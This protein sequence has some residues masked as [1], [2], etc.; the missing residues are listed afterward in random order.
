M[1]VPGGGTLPASKPFFPS[2]YGESPRI[3]PL[4]VAVKT[5]ALG[6]LPRHFHQGTFRGT[7]TVSYN[8]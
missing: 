5:P 2:R 4:V 7:G 3:Q 1:T 6:P 8:L